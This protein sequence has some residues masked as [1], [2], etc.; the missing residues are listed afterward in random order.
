M[1]P[2]CL[3]VAVLWP[4]PTGGRLQKRP[5]AYW[6][7]YGSQLVWECIRRWLKVASLLDCL[8]AG[9]MDGQ[10]LCWV[11]RNAQC[12]SRSGSGT[13]VWS[14]TNAA[15]LADFESW[16]RNRSHSWLSFRIKCCLTDEDDPCWR[17][18]AHLKNQCYSSGQMFKKQE[19]ASFG[20]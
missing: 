7:D 2:G 20:M 12:H 4:Q 16:Q 13:L 9:W 3:L 11:G 15:S 8:L 1:C 17:S 6:T 5:R 19:E 14:G 18:L 10:K